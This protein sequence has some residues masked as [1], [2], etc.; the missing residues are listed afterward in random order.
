[1][2]VYPLIFIA[3]DTAWGS[4][5]VTGGGSLLWAAGAA[6]GVAAHGLKIAF[7]KGGESLAPSDKIPDKFLGQSLLKF[8]MN[9]GAYTLGLFTKNYWRDVAARAGFYSQQEVYVTLLMPRI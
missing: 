8:L 3:A 7:G 2:K 1:M 4:Y 5:G 9:T 6:C